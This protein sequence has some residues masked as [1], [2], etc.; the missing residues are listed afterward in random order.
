MRIRV[1][2]VTKAEKGMA[3]IT[4]EVDQRYADLWMTNFPGWLEATVK[5][6][7]K[8]EIEHLGGPPAS[9]NEIDPIIHK[10]EPPKNKVIREGKSKPEPKN[11]DMQLLDRAIYHLGQSGIVEK[12][13]LGGHGHQEIC[14]WRTFD[15]IPEKHREKLRELVETHDK[16]EL[17]ARA[18]Y[19]KVT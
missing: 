10:P 15:E 12:L 14:V 18:A 9:Q 16:L 7:L 8:I 3:K 2:S 11:E 4:I 17:D 1:T 6:E 19:A 13:A 5:P